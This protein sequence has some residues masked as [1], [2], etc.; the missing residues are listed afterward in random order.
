VLSQPENAPLTLAEQAALLL[1]VEENLLD[2]LPL[3][4]VPVFQQALAAS[5]AKDLPGVTDRV[6][7]TGSIDEKDRTALLAYVKQALATLAPPEAEKDTQ[8]GA[9]RQT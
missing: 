4:V 8:D 9:T 2:P 1:A 6:N 7:R 5:L 3:S